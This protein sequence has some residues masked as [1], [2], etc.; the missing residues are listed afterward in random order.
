MMENQKAI[1][2]KGENSRIRVL[3]VGGGAAGMVAAVA[4]AREGA[5]TRL[6]EKN[7]KLGKKLFITGKGRCNVTCL[8]YTSPSPRDTR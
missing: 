5:D 7:E 3:V 4:A 6:F 8:L 2:G 1:Q